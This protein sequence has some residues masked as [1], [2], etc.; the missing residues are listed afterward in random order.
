MPSESGD[1]TLI[2]GPTSAIFSGGQQT[3]IGPPPVVG[4]FMH[5]HQVGGQ[6]DICASLNLG[7]TPRAE[8][9]ARLKEVMP[10]GPERV[11]RLIEKQ[12]DHEIQ[13]DQRRMSLEE[14]EF[15]GIQESNGQF[16]ARASRGQVMAFTL[17]L[18]VVVVAGILAVLGDAAAAATIGT[19]VGGTLGGMLIVGRWRSQSGSE[20]DPEDNGSE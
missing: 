9:L 17:G 7:V 12:T 3:W 5:D 1:E 15:V 8:E 11:F 18:G 13:M 4:A 6:I 16:H 20:D 2:V 14:A 19:V 10:D